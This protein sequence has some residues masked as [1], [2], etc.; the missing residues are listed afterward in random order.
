MSKIIDSGKH[1]IGN[2]TL[3]K[4]YLPDLHLNNLS[5]MFVSRELE[6]VKECSPVDITHTHTHITTISIFDIAISH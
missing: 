5:F 1:G 2:R 4:E 3:K 6:L